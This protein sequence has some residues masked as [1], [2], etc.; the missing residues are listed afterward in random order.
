MVSHLRVKHGISITSQGEAIAGK[1]KYTVR[2]QAWS[3]C[4]CVNV[5]SSFNGR[6]GH[7]A[8]KH[9]ENGDSIEE[10]DATNVI[11]GLLQQPGMIEA[12]EAKLK[13]LSDFMIADIIWEKDTIKD[14]QHNL[15]VGPSDETTAAS[16]ADAA[17]SACR[18]N[19]GME[20]K[21]PRVVLGPEVDGIN[22]TALLPS[23]LLS[24]P[25][26]SPPVYVPN[27]NEPLPTLR[28]PDGLYFSDLVDQSINQVDD[29][30]NSGLLSDWNDDADED[31]LTST[32]QYQA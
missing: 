25:T 27:H 31:S 20:S 14:L 21:R 2:K 24:A 29:V 22:D 8:T 12:W 3:C 7:I 10:W 11:K 13:S 30:S 16:L 9:F 5:F 23:S 6:L 17:Y 18:M 28:D 26:T 1:W 15:E 4:F 32:N 19:W